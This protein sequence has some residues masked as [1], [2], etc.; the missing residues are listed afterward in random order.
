MIM[1]MIMIVIIII[2]II[3]TVI[4]IIIII[5]IIIMRKKMNVS[6]QFCLRTLVKH[7]AMLLVAGNMAM[8][9]K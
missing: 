2:L 5:I 7:Y 9:K 3:T 1:I 4:T 6:S 8:C